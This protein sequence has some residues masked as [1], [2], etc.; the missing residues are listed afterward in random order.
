MRVI[1]LGKQ[2]EAKEQAEASFTIFLE[3]DGLGGLGCL[4]SEDLE[5]Q[6]SQRVQTGE[7]FLVVA[8]TLDLSLYSGTVIDQATRPEHL[9]KGGCY[10]RRLT[11]YEPTTV[12]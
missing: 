6:G 4:C 7:P 10:G 11:E 5:S 3:D 8:P 9:N 1:A 2:T 12:P